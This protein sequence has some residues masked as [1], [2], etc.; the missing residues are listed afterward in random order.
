M[1]RSEFIKCSVIGS[2]SL[3]LASQLDC[4][5]KSL[6]GT[7]QI[8]I[9][10]AYELKV[11]FPSNV[12]LDKIIALAVDF[13]KDW[14]AGKFDSARS[15][16]EN[17]D[18]TIQQVITDLDVNATPRVKLLLASL[19][20]ALRVVAALIDEQG[21]SQPKAAAMARATASRTVDRV[22]QLSNSSDADS[23]LKAV[24]H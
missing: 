15:L 18:S 2:A 14:V 21:A 13:N 19:G 7:V 24:K 20:V 8:L 6:S 23:I 17:L 12:L 1:N 10:G 16:F 4:G 9:S 5:G 11:L 22:K 3:I